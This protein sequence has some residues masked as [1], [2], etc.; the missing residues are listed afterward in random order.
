MAT[1][2]SLFATVSWLYIV[3]AVSG[4]VVQETGAGERDAAVTQ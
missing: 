2:T 1:S 4:A 3:A